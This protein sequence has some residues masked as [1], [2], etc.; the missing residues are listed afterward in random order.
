[1]RNPVD[2]IASASPDVIGRA[3]EL[4]LTADEIDALV[5]LYVAPVVT[6]PGDV[7]AAVLAA[8][9][10]GANLPIAACFLG[11]DVPAG[12]LRDGGDGPVIPTFPF[13]ESAVTALGRA[14]G[15]AEWRRSPP[16]LVPRI[17]GIDQEAARGVLRDAL[18]ANPAGGWVDAAAAGR[19]LAAFGIPMVPTALVSSAAEAVSVADGLGYPVVLKA[20]APELV[21]KTERGAVAL[22]LDSAAFASM[23]GALGREMGGGLVQPMAAPGVELIAGVTQDRVFGPLVLFGMGGVGAELIRDTSLRLL[24]LTGLDAHDMVRSLRTSPLLFGYRGSEGVDVPAVEDLL[25]RL[26]RLA[27]LPE[28]AELDCNPVV[29]SP[30][31][32]L[33]LDVK[34]RVQPAPPAETFTLEP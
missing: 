9:R 12:P 6:R 28:I 14:A 23:E 11:A 24:P 21:H 25:L 22:D 26:G 29:A 3:A 20:A 5:V 7:E 13:P 1:V 27:E 17:A 19:L 31:G 10:T 15:L 18:A 4:L 16:P 8:A 33:V 2:V 34:L 30:R 32:A